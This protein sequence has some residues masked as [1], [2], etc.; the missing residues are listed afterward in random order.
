MNFFKILALVSLLTSWLE[1]ATADGE[2]TIDE[3]SEL[4]VKAIA[5]LGL[6]EDIKI[7]L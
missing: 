5:Q 3:V 4:V 6:S 1:D 7:K 2:I